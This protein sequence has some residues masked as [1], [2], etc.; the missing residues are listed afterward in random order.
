MHTWHDNNNILN[1]ENFLL[2]IGEISEISETGTVVEPTTTYF[3][4]NN[5][6]FGQTNQMI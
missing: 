4:K 5:W 1:I 2:Q 3:L 6:T